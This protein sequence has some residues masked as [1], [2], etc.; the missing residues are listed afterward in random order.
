[1]KIIRPWALASLLL[2]VGI[3]ACIATPTP[4]PQPPPAVP[5]VVLTFT[6]APV[7]PDLATFTDGDG[8]MITGTVVE[9]PPTWSYTITSGSGKGRLLF[10]TVR[11]QSSKSAIDDCKV[12]KT[13]P[14]GVIISS[15]AATVIS[16]QIPSGLG[17]P[18]VTIVLKCDKAS[19]GGAVKLGLDY[20][21]FTSNLIDKTSSVVVGT[22]A[23]PQY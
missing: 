21:Y 8:N 7:A 19:Y 12:T 20:S 5:P 9:N 14:G 3:L 1:M 13:V 22:L 23:G 17:V 4:P 2:V 18:P 15:P 16:I 11:I 6:A 10:E